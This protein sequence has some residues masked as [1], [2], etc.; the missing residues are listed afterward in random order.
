MT[1]D[2]AGEQLRATRVERCVGRPAVGIDHI[3]KGSR[4]GRQGS[5][6]GY[7]A[8]SKSGLNLKPE[9]FK[10]QASSLQTPWGEQEE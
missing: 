9:Q 3:I 6:R 5:D 4:P 2:P 8:G 10:P 1:F 7:R